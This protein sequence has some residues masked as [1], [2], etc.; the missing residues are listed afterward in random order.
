M[1]TENSEFF[2]VIPSNTSLERHPNNTSSD[3]TVSLTD[4]IKLAPK[5]EWK[6]ALMDMCYSHERIDDCGIT[7][8]FYSE[9]RPVYDYQLTITYPEYKVVPPSR[10]FGNTESGMITIEC[11]IYKSILIFWSK[12]VPFELKT[13]HGPMEKLHFHPHWKQYYCQD[14]AFPTTLYFPIKGRPETKTLNYSIIPYHYIEKESF[15]PITKQIMKLTRH[16]IVHYMNSTYD[17]IFHQLDIKDNIVKFG[18]AKRVYLIKFSGGLGEALGFGKDYEFAATPSEK[19]YLSSSHN[20]E[21]SINIFHGS[22]ETPSYIS[23]SYHDLNILSNI[24]KLVEV[25][26]SRIPLLK[27]VSIDI[28]PASGSHGYVRNL[29]ISR[30]S[31]MGVRNKTISKIH[32]DIRNRVGKKVTFQNGSSTVITLHFKCS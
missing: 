14:S 20:F 31:Y 2:M 11:T 27:S 16:E 13:W 18:L 26:N 28:H 5:K 32:I 3:F 29:V 9:W 12:T 4:P 21:R 24:C 6:V 15:Y 8:K 1:T 30:P 17:F 23:S 25:G 22:S 19:H 7:Y 10:T